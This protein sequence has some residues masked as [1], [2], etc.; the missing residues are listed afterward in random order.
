MAARPGDKRTARSYN[1][2]RCIIEDLQDNVLG[3][4]AWLR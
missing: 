2:L 4:V 3:I 1:T